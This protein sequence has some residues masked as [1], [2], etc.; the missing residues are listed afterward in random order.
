MNRR[1]FL[2]STGLAGLGLLYGSLPIM[3]GPLPVGDDQPLIPLDKKLKPAWVRSLFEKGSPIVYTKAN[4]ELKFIGMPVGGICC[5]TVYLGGDGRLW[6]WDVFNANSNGIYPRTVSY[7][8]FGG[9]AS[10][11]NQNGANYV[12]PQPEDV[13]L[14]QGFSLKL[15]DTVTPLSVDGWKDVSFKGEYPLGIVDY[16]DPKAQVAVNL[17]AY[18]PF[19]P[20]DAD[21]SGLP[22]VV[23]EI[24]LHNKGTKPLT[25]E[26]AGYLEN[27]VR[28]NSIQSTP[29]SRRNT[30]RRA[31]GN[32][33]IF[34]DFVAAQ[35]EAAP[36]PDVLFDD[37]EHDTYVGWTVEGDAFGSGPI[38]RSDIP[39]Y[40][41]DVGGVGDRVVN[42]HASAPGGSVE[43][44]DSHTGTLTSMPFTVQRKYLSFYIGGGSNID[45]VGLALLVD[46]KVVRRATGKDDNHM[47]RSSFDVTEFAGK[48][49]QIKIYDHGTGPWGNIGVDDIVQT[50]IA[51]ADAADKDRDNGTMAIAVGG[52]ATARP[53][54][55]PET[56]FFGA[57]NDSAELP[58]GGRL[59]GSVSV[60][61]RLAAGQ[62]KSVT[63]VVAW[64]FPTPAIA[65]SDAAKG[66]YYSVK[67][68]DAGAVAAYVLQNLPRLSKLTHAWHDAWY[69]STLPYW[70]LNRTMTNTSI[71]ATSTAHRFG[72]G[73][74]WGWEGVGCCWG[75]CCH[76]WH[77]GQATG[78]L[79]PELERYTREHV[80]LGVAFNQQ[81]GMIGNRGEGSGPAV[82]GQ[83]G[84]ILGVYREHQT[85]ADKGFL[86]RVWPHVKLA[87]GYLS[88]HDVD[89][90]GL[91]EGAQDNTLDAAWYG[92]IA[93]I[94]SLY[95]AALLA[96]AEMANEMGDTD[97]EAD[98]R[99]R[100]AK[101]K[102]SI[103]T[104]LYNGEYFI[105]IADPAHLGAL[106]VYGTSHIDQVMGQG[107]AWQVGLGRVIDKDKTVSALKALYKYNFAPDVG[108]YRER[109]H[110]GRPYA[111]AG[112][113]GL[114][115]ATNP[116]NLPNPFGN[117]SDWQYGYFN[118]CMSGFEHQAAGHMIAEGLL[119]EGLAVTRAVHDR[120]NAKLRNPY[121]EIEC[122][123]HYSRAMAS[124]GS[125]LS[126]CGFEYHGPKGHIGFSPR[127]APERFRC[128]FTAAEGWGS[129]GQNQA[130]GK[131]TSEL[132]MRHGSLKLKTM[133]VALPAGT[134]STSVTATLNGK[135][136]RATLAVA[137]S[138]ARVT[139]AA[140]ITVDEGQILRVFV[141]YSLSK[142]I[143]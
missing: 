8:G 26:L 125:F 110:P 27:A 22:C 75:T 120:Y 54:V 138:R 107:W 118:E 59:V 114:I 78:R 115:M 51:V 134:T 21:D 62:S 136:M 30:V 80:D 19:I 102:N 79:F 6:V 90:D 93:W 84:R 28:I 11:N 73:R 83:A 72:T 2:A 13:G 1:G 127:L 16:A 76:V 121:N 49:A 123:D 100:F 56:V 4:D 65:V 42:S 141:P 143:L 98:C 69:D 55:V 97:F 88:A 112:D 37:F 116:K 131:H 60:P 92:K 99:A 124:Y 85:S 117:V 43:Q 57:P 17:T 18:S 66:N 103:E 58:N 77:Y 53:G 91:L 142:P 45:Q 126:A 67:H 96:C 128:A 3:A 46:G 25:G 109:N 5:G 108:P 52:A 87:I 104:Q 70:F 101:S 40:Q 15:G 63:F 106:G 9:Q 48:T 111:L 68:A 81:T 140:E 23:F 132:T 47:A 41:G 133:A 31:A 10:V 50:D 61:V 94:S 32:T 20:L 122:S 95:A 130:D 44:K 71:L 105:Q 129:Y 135:P 113:A 137:D 35:N 29:G 86:T 139:F 89:G 74:F 64:H 7:P 38:K 12:S 82:D 34:S 24:T 36:R 33:I 119:L 39:G 14:I